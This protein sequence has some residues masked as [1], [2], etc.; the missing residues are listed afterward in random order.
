VEMKLLLLLT[1]VFLAA[2]LVSPAAYPPPGVTRWQMLIEA[3][4]I[5]YWFFPTLAFAWSLLWLFSK[6]NRALKAVS[7]V[8]LALMCFGILRDWWI[9][10]FKDLHWAENA[11]L[12]DDAPAGTTLVFPENPEGW[13][14]RLVKGEPSIGR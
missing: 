14:I 9:P 12:V 4:G 8:L 10:P 11:K 1:T 7:S 5:R 3:G 2:S 6:S 13:D